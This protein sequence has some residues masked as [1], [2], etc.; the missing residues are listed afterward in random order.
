MVR[1][2]L[3]FYLTGK[4]KPEHQDR[5]YGPWIF[6]WFS[7]MCKRDYKVR[8]IIVSMLVICEKLGLKW[9]ANASTFADAYWVVARGIRFFLDCLIL[10]TSFSYILKKKIPHCL[11][12]EIFSSLIQ[13]FLQICMSFSIM[14]FQM[15]F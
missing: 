8:T 5:R 3:L 9:L 6:P 2:C 10:S 14:F 11:I 1:G 4:T 12:V 15:H 13:L 7:I